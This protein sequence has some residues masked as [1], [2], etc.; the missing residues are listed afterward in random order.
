MT[1]CR[2]TRTHP[3]L[4]SGGPPRFTCVISTCDY[5][6]CSMPHPRC[7]VGTR[8]EFCG[9]VERRLDTQRETFKMQHATSNVHHA[10]CNSLRSSKMPCTA[11]TGCFLLWVLQGAA[12]YCRCCNV[13]LFRVR[14]RTLG[15][16][17][18]AMKAPPESS[19][20]AVGTAGCVSQSAVGLFVSLTSA[21]RKLI[22]VL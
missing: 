15:T 9:N 16:T 19:S 5:A 6:T 11:D 12:P 13:G 2:E 20:S 21:H 10:T 4:P 17:V 7:T 3:A 8:E 1:C 22:R 18:R 14:C